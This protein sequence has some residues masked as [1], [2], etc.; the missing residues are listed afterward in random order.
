MR[1]IGWCCLVSLALSCGAAQQGEQA[2][3]GG[4]EELF[5]FASAPVAG[6]IDEGVDSVSASLSARPLMRMPFRCGQTWV[7]QTR[8]NHSPQQA[9][10]FN[11]SED[12]A[13]AVVAS[14]DGKVTRSESEGDVSYGNWIEIEHA[15]GYRTRYAHLSVRGVRVGERVRMGD[16]IGEVGNSGGSTG[17]HLHYEQLSG[18]TPIAVRLASTAVNYFE[19]RAYTSRNGCR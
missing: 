4:Q 3:Q 16:K 15:G 8:S 13:D 12:F 18:T 5:D 2:Q 11:R 9:V 10:D 1:S 14:A 6:A 7:A 19:T 17:P